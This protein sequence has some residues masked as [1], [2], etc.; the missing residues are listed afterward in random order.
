MQSRLLIRRS[1]PNVRENPAFH[2]KLPESIPNA[3]G[4]I[5]LLPLGTQ[6]PVFSF[7][8]TD[9]H[10]QIK[11]ECP[12]VAEILEVLKSEPDWVK[13]KLREYYLAGTPRVHKPTDI[14]RRTVDGSAPEQIW[15][16]EQVKYPVHVNF[17]GWTRPLRSFRKVQALVSI[18]TDMIPEKTVEALI[19][20]KFIK[21]FVGRECRCR[22]FAGH[23]YHVWIYG[24]EGR[25]WIGALVDK[26]ANITLSVIESDKQNVY[27]QAIA[28]GHGKWISNGGIR[29][30]HESINAA[31]RGEPVTF[32]Q[33]GKGTTKS[34]CDQKTNIQSKSDLASDVS[35]GTSRVLPVSTEGLQNRLKEIKNEIS[36]KKEEVDRLELED[37]VVGF[38]QANEELSDLYDEENEI[39]QKLEE[40]P[41]PTS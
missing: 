6:V 40:L 33:R 24:E 14:D 39:I 38:D 13:F 25:G 21:D 12:R 37:D 15:D 17:A 1:L 22:F 31:L 30:T 4:N 32:R 8:E 10:R 19:A 26:F 28:N 34:T 23:H 11:E 2:A 16:G 9:Q 27:M 3:L 35:T 41:L 7:T 29:F 20:N 18:P 36:L 5:P